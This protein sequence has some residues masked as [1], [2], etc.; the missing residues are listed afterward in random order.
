[1]SL[2]L[3]QCGKILAWDFPVKTSLLVNEQFYYVAELVHNKEE[4]SD[5]SPKEFEFFGLLNLFWQIAFS[6]LYTKQKGFY[7]QEISFPPCSEDNFI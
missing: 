5:W 7:L 6:I 1:M 3:G 2:S 4:N